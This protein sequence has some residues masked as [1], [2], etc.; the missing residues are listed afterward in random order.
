MIMEVAP[1]IRIISGFV[2]CLA[3]IVCGREAV[4]ASADPDKDPHTLTLLEEVRPL[5]DAK[6][7]EG[8]IEKCDQI[9]ALF[10]AH[11]GSSKHKIYCA[12]TPAESLGYLMIAA[13]AI[14]KGTF[15]TGKRDAIVLS[16]TWASAYFLKAYALQDLSRISEARST[17]RLAVELSPWSCLYLCEL[18]SIYKLEKNWARAK[19]AYETAEGQASLSPDNVKAAELG[20]A[21][22][23]LGY[24]MVELGQLDEAERKYQQCLAADP[25]DAKAA[26]ELEYVRG[27]KAKRKSR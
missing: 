10:K 19:E 4:A 16:A 1:G 12:R 14:N 18:G 25:N 9:I 20:Q 5:I 3:A 8:A 24:V 22:R 13:A 27:L 23:G 6:N 2:S 7:P 11:Y 26:A 15:E 21:R 17:I